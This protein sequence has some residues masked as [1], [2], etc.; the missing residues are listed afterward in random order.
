[1]ARVAGWSAIQRTANATGASIQDMG[2]DH[3]GAD[4]LVTEELLDRADV[5][6][7]F[8]QVS[9]EGVAEGV[10]RD[11]LGNSGGA[12]G[13]PDLFLNDRLVE[14]VATGLAGGRVE[15]GSSRGARAIDWAVR[16]T[17]NELRHRARVTIDAAP[18][19]PAAKVGEVV[20]KAKAPE[21]LQL[22]Q[23]GETFDAILC[24]LMMPEMSGIELYEQLLAT[25]PEQAARM[26]LMTGGA[27]TAK[28]ADFLR[29]VPNA[30]VESPFRVSTLRQA[31]QRLVERTKAGRAG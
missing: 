11:V 22:I 17:S 4:V 27:L 18:N 13:P 12:G 28:A 2:V 29:T 20:C 23:S 14:V 7:G 21:A 30:H 9:C 16:A 8:Q 1:M 15:V 31:V 10:R 19:L 5:V 6:A 26:I 25:R 24:D 3:C